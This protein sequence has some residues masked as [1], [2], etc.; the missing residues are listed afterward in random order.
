MDCFQDFCLACDKQCTEGSYCSQACRLAELERAS[1]APTSPTTPAGFEN[2]YALSSA[3]GFPPQ[4]QKRFSMSSV[5]VD[6][7]QYHAML[8]KVRDRR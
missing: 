7:E 1:N 3:Y 8:L 2:S 4:D 6:P 5:L